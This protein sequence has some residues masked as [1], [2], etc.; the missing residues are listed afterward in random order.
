MPGWGCGRGMSTRDPPVHHS[1]AL[2]CPAFGVGVTK[3][4]T[5]ASGVEGPHQTHLTGLAATPRISKTR[6][7]AT[8]TVPLSFASIVAVFWLQV[9]R[10]GEYCCIWLGGWVWIKKGS[11]R[12]KMA[13]ARAHG[14]AL[15]SPQC[16]SDITKHLENIGGEHL[17][18]AKIREQPP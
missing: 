5:A 11:L 14:L 3:A 6:Q 2:R 8:T 16:P 18:E 15:F 10:T 17:A 12:V 7:A 13:P 1:P 9:D 4:F